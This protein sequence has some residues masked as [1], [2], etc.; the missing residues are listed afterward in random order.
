MTLLVAVAGVL[1]L[2]IGLTILFSPARMRWGLKNMITRRMVPVLSILRI[3]F[4]IVFVL[5]APSTRLPMV[6]WVFGLFMILAGVS[7]PFL[8]IERLQKRSA[9]WLKRSDGVIRGWSLVVILLGV[10]L[11]WAALG[12]DS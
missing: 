10:L 11:I 2:G 6:V 12:L 5:A 7:L 9:E 1:I 4:G 3:G 8:G